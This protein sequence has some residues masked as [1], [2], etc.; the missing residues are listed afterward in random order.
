MAVASF[1][2]VFG[3]LGMVYAMMSIGLLGFVV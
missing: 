2:S 3:Y 1:K